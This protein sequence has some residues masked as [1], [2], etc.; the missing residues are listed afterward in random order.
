NDEST[1]MFM[2]CFYE[3]LASTANKA[4]ALQHAMRSL[5]ATYPHP[6]HWA[7]FVL[8]GKFS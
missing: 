3:G 8:I 1:A 5:R 7:P 4:V 6:Y 2:K